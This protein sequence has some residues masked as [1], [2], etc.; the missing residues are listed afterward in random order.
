[1]RGAGIGSARLS[2]ASG[3]RELFRNSPSRSGFHLLQLLLV[4][5]EPLLG[6]MFCSPARLVALQGRIQGVCLPSKLSVHGCEAKRKLSLKLSLQLSLTIFGQLKLTIAAPARKGF[7][8][9]CGSHVV[10]H[11]RNPV[12]QAARS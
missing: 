8:P 5:H 12:P 9:R 1:M 3:R 6:L 10:V 11:D 2:A 7:L 4:V